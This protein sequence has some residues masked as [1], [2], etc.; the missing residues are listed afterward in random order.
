M[1]TNTVGKRLLRLVD[2]TAEHGDMLTQVTADQ[3]AVDMP[4]HIRW[5]E[6]DRPLLLQLALLI[7][8]PRG[9]ELEQHG[10]ER[11][12]GAMPGDIRQIKRQLSFRHTKVVDEIA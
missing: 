6:P 5:L 2:D 4:K 12:R 11:R 9:H 7:E 10:D 8:Q 1:P 3:A